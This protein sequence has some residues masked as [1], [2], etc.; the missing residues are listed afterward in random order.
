[1]KFIA[2]SRQVGQ[3]K[4]YQSVPEHQHNHELAAKG[5]EEVRRIRIASKGLCKALDSLWLCPDHSEHSANLQLRLGIDEGASTPPPT[6]QFSL[7]VTSWALDTYDGL[8]KPI[9]LLVQSSLKKVSE[10][11]EDTTSEACE[12]RRRLLESIDG[13]HI[14]GFQ[15]L[16]SPDKTIAADEQASK[17]TERPGENQSQLSDL[18]KSSAHLCRSFHNGSSSST[19]T[20]T[21][22]LGYLPGFLVYRNEPSRYFAR[23]TPLA[24]LLS[25]RNCQRGLN[26]LEK[27][28]L[29]TSLAMAVLQYHSTP[30]LQS[31]KWMDN[32]IMFFED[33]ATTE[34][35]KSPESLHLQL[36]PQ[37]SAADEDDTEEAISAFSHDPFIKNQTLFQL[38]MILLELEF[39]ES[40]EGITKRWDKHVVSGT[41]QDCNNNG[42]WARRL[43]AP[44]F[45]AGDKLGPDY[46][47]IVRMCLDCD[48]GLGLSDYS[49]DNDKLQ[50][51]FYLQIVC[52]FR[53]LLPSWEK[54]YS[55]PTLA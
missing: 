28:K 45:H 44:K 17:L 35:I 52:Q 39:E 42:S 4:G 50:E 22:S 41:T 33:D 37:S 10:N 5:L 51:A 11:M 31:E 55:F 43:I 8:K 30:W 47:R 24:R 48:F 26:N 40:L 18:C 54:I 25:E 36:L 1:M 38:G 23:A 32:G 15:N 16:K 3:F 14:E 27:W 21:T 46:G 53:K 34:G 29:A 6:I 13:S 2:L 19:S 49:L 7:M 20:T 12:F 9:E